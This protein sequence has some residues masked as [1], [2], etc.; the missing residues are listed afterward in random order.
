ME[1]K[2]TDRR[3]QRTQEALRNALVELILEKGYPKITVQNIIDRA[4]VGR[5]TFYAHFL[6]KDDLLVSGFR[7]WAFDL[8]RNVGDGENTPDDGH[9]IHSQDFFLHADHH[10]DL[11]RAMLE[12]GGG[13]LILKVGQEHIH[14]Q[15]ESHL[16][17]LLGGKELPIPLPFITNYLAGALLSLIKWW[18]EEDIPFDALQMDAMFQ[19]MAMPGIR[20]AIMG[21]SNTR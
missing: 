17:E 6:D 13:N 10:R 19:A 15:I 12:S 20:D 1:S 18:I 2:K 4:N 14:H 21:N 8:S 16:V 7:A 9:I 11:Y 5:S 3:I